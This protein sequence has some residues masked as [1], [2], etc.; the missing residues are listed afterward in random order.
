VQRRIAY[1]QAACGRHHCFDYCAGAMLTMG[2]VQE[3]S[4]SHPGQG[5]AHLA[6]HC[7]ENASWALDKRA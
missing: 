1:S 6:A 3:R 7:A 2:A 5:Q 4:D